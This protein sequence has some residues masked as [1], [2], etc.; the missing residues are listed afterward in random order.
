MAPKAPFIVLNSVLTL[1]YIAYFN[2][3]IIE[4]EMGFY[5]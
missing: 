4:I 2:L 3:N 1:H 5:F